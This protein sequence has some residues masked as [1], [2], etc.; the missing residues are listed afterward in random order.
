MT[1]AEAVTEVTARTPWVGARDTRSDVAVAGEPTARGWVWTTWA[2]AEPPEV[3]R[4]QRGR[5]S[6]Y[7]AL[8][9][10]ASTLTREDKRTPISEPE[11]R[12]HFPEFGDSTN[13]M[14]EGVSFT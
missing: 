14:P 7:S 2:G 3:C 11:E 9:F 4:R 5:S 1:T 6:G 13:C 8:S 12:K 10:K